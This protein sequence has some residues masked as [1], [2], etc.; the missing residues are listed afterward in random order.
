ML[1]MDCDSEKQETF[2]FNLVFC[3]GHLPFACGCK[4]AVDSIVE[5]SLP[6]FLA[7]FI[8][9]VTG[10]P[11]SF[12]HPCVDLPFLALKERN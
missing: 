8:G 12:C 2:L 5:F 11:G 1:V 7:D 10:L 9:N 4:G 6:C 3:S